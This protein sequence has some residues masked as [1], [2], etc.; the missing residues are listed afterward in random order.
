MD[1]SIVIVNYNTKILLTDCLYSIYENT[2]EVEFEVIVVDNAS[3]DGSKEY[4]ERLFP[5]VRWFENQYNLGFGI[6]NNF[7]AKKANGKYLFLL[8]S[9]T[10]LK[11]NAVKLFWDYAECEKN[12]LVGAIGCWLRN[13]EGE[14][15]S[16]YG[17]FPSVKKEFEYLLGRLKKRN[18]ESPVILDVDYITGADIFIKKDLFNKVGGFDPNFFMYYEETDLQ[19]RLSSLNWKRRLITSPQ[20]IHLEG[21][22][23]GKNGLTFKRFV[24]A[25]RSYNYF[26]RKHKYGMRYLWHK[27]A[28]AVIRLT[29]FVSRWSWKEKFDAYM[30][31]LRK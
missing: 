19:F 29:V 28:L 13:S 6:A 17:F 22:S 20:I 10:I 4:I 3:S 24:M 16:S 9:D 23:F 18:S 1:V 7:G 27:V 5:K 2:T 25:Q 30:L 21:G 31:V 15:C 8:N 14:I 26:L 11:N 12:N